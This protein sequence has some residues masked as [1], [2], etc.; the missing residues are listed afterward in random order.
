[1]THDSTIY[2]HFWHLPLL[3]SRCLDKLREVYSI[4][5]RF[6]SNSVHFIAQFWLSC[7]IFMS[8]HQS[9][10]IHASFFWEFE[11]NQWLSSLGLIPSTKLW[12][13]PGWY[14][15]ENIGFWSTSAKNHEKWPFF[16]VLAPSESIFFR[17]HSRNMI[18]STWFI[19]YFYF[20]ARI[21]TSLH[22][23]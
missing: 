17:F 22:R 10:E 5:S 2:A 4:C 14:H 9:A 1:M 12:Q 19:V 16:T 13:S 15:T 3:H 6:Y 20:L 18:F 23:M 21:G 7:W 11:S 8:L